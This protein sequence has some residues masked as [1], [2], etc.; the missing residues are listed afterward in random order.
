MEYS[1]ISFLLPRREDAGLVN[2]Q[3]SNKMSYIS[4]RPKLCGAIRAYPL[5]TLQ[6]IN[7]PYP[8]FS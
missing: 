6:C 8:L 1:R 3:G 5:S 7:H 4:G 2:F